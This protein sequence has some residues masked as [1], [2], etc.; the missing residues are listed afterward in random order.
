MTKDTVINFFQNPPAGEPEQFNQA[1]NL[2][3][4]S[5]N[6]NAGLVRKYNVSGYTKNSLQNL[7]YDLQQLHGIKDVEKIPVKEIKVNEPQV[8]KPLDNND[9]KKSDDDLETINKGSNQK[10]REEYTF[11]AEPDCPKELKILATDKITAYNAYK[12]IHE[13]LQQ[14]KEGKLEISEEEKIKLADEAVELF[15]ESELIKAELDYYQENKKI[16]AKHPIFKKLALE[17]IVD[18]MPNDKCLAYIKNTP[19]YIS[20]KK[21]AIEKAEGDQKEKLQSQLEERK[22][23]LKLVQEKLGISDK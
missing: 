12:A 6:H 22:S 18:K 21:K 4:L 13:K 23:V 17:R 3:R 8:L 10:F 15:N 9:S 1:L 7:L 19:P 14:V 5:K 11:L 2:Y 16:K 20:K